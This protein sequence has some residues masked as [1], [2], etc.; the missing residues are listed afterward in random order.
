MK[1][2]IRIAAVLGIMLFS[3]LSCREELFELVGDHDIDLIY[4]DDVSFTQ[5]PATFVRGISDGRIEIEGPGTI[6]LRIV[7]VSSEIVE[8]LSI[9]WIQG[10]LV[11]LS[12]F[13]LPGFPAIQIPPYDFSIDYTGGDD[14]SDTFR[15]VYRTGGSSSR[16]FFVVVNGNL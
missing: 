12:F 13:A 7:N 3:L 14:E 15:I 11:E 9:T 4:S 2:V 5:P 16:E 8:L 10:P 6:Y 1:P